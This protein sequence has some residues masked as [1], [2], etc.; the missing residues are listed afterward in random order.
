MT[1]RFFVAGM[2][3]V[4][5]CGGSVSTDQEVIGQRDDAV[6]GGQI[7]YLDPSVVFI[8]A[9]APG[10]DTGI[11]CSGAII[12]PRSVLTAAHCVVPSAV[13]ENAV[14]EVQFSTFANRHAYQ[15]AVTNVAFDPEF[16]LSDFRKGHDIAILTLAQPTY[17]P[18][19]PIN[20]DSSAVKAGKNVRIVGF[21]AN[22]HDGTG[23]GTKRY[24]YATINSVE[25]NIIYIGDSDRQNCYGDSG[26]PALMNINGKITLVGIT[27]YGYDLSSTSL[28]FGGAYSTQVDKYLDFIDSHIQ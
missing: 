3:L 5:A 1:S 27:S 2:F 7:A 17:M 8:F 25:N 18:S 4:A 20:R 6:I 26:G 28:C 13:G 10:S 15:M 14:F 16:D 22:S 24:T 12:A 23:G 19:I 11:M 21:G 9:H